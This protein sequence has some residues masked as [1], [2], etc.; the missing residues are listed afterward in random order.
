MNNRRIY[1]KTPTITGNGLKNFACAVLFLQSTGIIIFEKGIIHLEQYT[2]ESLS[3]EMAKNQKLMTLAGTASVLQL[4]GGLA[5]PV[6]AFLLVEGFYHTSDYRTYLMAVFFTAAVSEIPYD[7]AMSGKI[8]DLSQQ[9]AVTGTGISLLMLYFLKM[10][11][12]QK[13]GRNLVQLFIVLC[14]V[15]WVTILRAEYG[16]CMVL[17]TAV[18]YIFYARNILK[19]VIGALISLLYVTG[20]LSFYA[21]WCYNEERKKTVSKYI[22]YAFYPVHLL[23]LGVIARN[24]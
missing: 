6:F 10:A 23:V 24:L 5:I 16:L 12:K 22:Y 17:L 21:I 1:W 18:F 2:Q 8:F 20:P 11:K 4:L 9:N 19:T 7:F 3:M 15:L 13:R 14:S